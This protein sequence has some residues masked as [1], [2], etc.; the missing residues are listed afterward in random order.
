MNLNWCGRKGPWPNLRYCPAFFIEGLWKTSKYLGISCLQAEIWTLDLPNT[1]QF[2][3]FAHSTAFA[4]YMF[5]NCSHQVVTLI[6]RGGVTCML[7]RQLPYLRLIFFL[8]LQRLTVP[9]MTG[10][11]ARH[12]RC[13]RKRFKKYGVT[14]VPSDTTFIPILITICCMQ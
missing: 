6:C 2:A 10:S 12:R 14:A 7:W 1:K 3:T 9:H 5:I 13:W 4:P 8:D 11:P